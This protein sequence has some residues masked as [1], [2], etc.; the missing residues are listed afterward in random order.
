MLRLFPRDLRAEGTGLVKAAHKR[1]HSSEELPHWYGYLYTVY[2]CAYRT[3]W[4][5]VGTWSTK[6][7]AEY[8]VVPRS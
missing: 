5:D 8:K 3:K 1:V 7:V 6:W 2:K 4:S